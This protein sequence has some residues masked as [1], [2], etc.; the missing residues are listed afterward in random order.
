MSVLNSPLYQPVTNRLYAWRYGNNKV[1]MVTLD[2]DGRVVDLVSPDAL[3]LHI[4]Y[5]NVNHINAV[6]DAGFTALTASFGYDAND[7]LTTVTRNNGDNQT[8][9]WDKSDNR[10]SHTRATAANAYSPATT[11][12]RLDT[13]SGSNPR[14]FTHDAVGNLYSDARSGAT[15]TYAFDPFNRLG[16]VWLNGTQTADYRHNASNQRV[17]KGAGSAVTRFVHTAQGQLLYEDA[18]QATHYVWIGGALLGIFRGGQFYYA[19]NDYVGRPEVMTNASGAVVW[20]AENAVFDRKVDPVW[21]VGL[22]L[23]FPGQ[24]FDAE[25]GLWYNWNRYYD[26]ST[27]RYVQSD[28][29]G[30]AGGINTYSYVGGNPIS[31]VDPS[32]LGQCFYSVSSGQMNCYS[33]FAGQGGFSGQFASGNNSIPGCKNNPACTG[34]TGV[35]PIPTGH[36]YW[37]ASGKSGKPGGRF[38]VPVQVDAS[39]SNI[40]SHSCDNPFGPSKVGPFCSEG[41]LTGTVGTI[42]AL[43]Q[44]LGSEWAGGASNTLRVGP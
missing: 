3:N 1:R 9:S 10:L 33:D 20:R 40:R 29:I 19:H 8:F 23:G 4:G 38:L 6:G 18:A 42:G 31:K 7:R 11:S 44:F 25:S 35:G 32:G 36:W 13:V 15:Q 27:G 39:R 17:Y 24:Y 21:I 2:T 41:C 22:N 28:P 43:N 14:S 5:D 26:A 30:L 12:N 37:D 16:A 34:E